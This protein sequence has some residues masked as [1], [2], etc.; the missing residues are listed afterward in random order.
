MRI[1]LASDLHVEFLAKRF[2]GQTRLTPA[3]NAD[4]LVL[5]G[6]VANGVRAIEHF[7]DWP[8]P[9]IYVLGNHEFYGNCWEDVR[10]AVRRDAEGTSVHVVERDSLELD[11]VRILGCTL[12]T[13]YLLQGH[14][15]RPYMMEYARGCLNDHNLIRTRLG[16]AFQPADALDD[17]ER[18]RA[19]LEDALARPYQGRTVVVTH[20]APHVQS[21]H[22]RFADSYL[23]AAF[24]SDLM[25]LVAQADLWMHGHMHDSSDYRI[26]RCR[27]M[28]N[29]RGYPMNMLSASTS[30]ALRFENGVFDEACVVDIGADFTSAS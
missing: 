20:H 1:Q 13:D 7:K 18:S 19:W 14:A 24:V 12:W 17:H 21:I 28:C 29:P 15:A 26:G 8:V 23:N 5:A 16:R 4:V 25:P 30:S 11:G 2:P 22:P 6:D 9:V 27:V 10:D 3:R